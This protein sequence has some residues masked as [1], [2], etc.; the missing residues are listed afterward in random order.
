M[1]LSVDRQKRC[2]CR[3]WGRNK[4]KIFRADGLL[5]RLHLSQIMI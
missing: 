1:R 3:G 5:W 4:S 2:D